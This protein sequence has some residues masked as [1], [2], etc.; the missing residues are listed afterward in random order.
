MIGSGVLFHIPHASVEIPLSPRE[1]ILLS[2]E[3]LADEVLKMTDWFVHEWI[4]PLPI[5]ADFVRFPVSRLVVDPERFREDAVEPM[6]RV[7]M[8]AVYTRTHGG[9]VLR[10]ENQRIREELLKKYYDP[11]HDDL[12]KTARGSIEK[13]GKCLLLDLHSFPSLALPYEIKAQGEAAVERPDICIGTCAYHTPP[14][15]AS[16]IESFCREQAWSC[17]KDQPFSGTMVPMSLYKKDKRLVSVMLE[18]RRGL[19]MDEK[20]GERLQGYAAFYEKIRGLLMQLCDLD[21]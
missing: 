19:Y 5:G 17:C 16:F 1:D 20:T 11:H 2:E 9:R 4:D 15:L 13:K 3:E 14:A 6:S 10:V 18:V 8:G 12:E 21:F 7:G